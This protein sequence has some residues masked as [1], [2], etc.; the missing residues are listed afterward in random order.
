MTLKRT[1]THLLK[2]IDNKKLSKEPINPPK[3][4]ILSL[5]TELQAQ[6][7]FFLP[8]FDQ[9]SASQVCLLW[10]NIL[11]EASY[12]RY[13]ISSNP[14]LPSIHQI[15]GGPLQPS[16]FEETSSFWISCTLKK[17]R[18]TKYEYAEYNND[19]NGKPLL[20]IIDIS[21]HEFL[22]EPI[23]SP[24]T[25]IGYSPRMGRLKHADNY[26]GKHTYGFEESG[27]NGV[28]AQDGDT[29]LPYFPYHPTVASA[30]AE[31]GD[32]G[33]HE[34]P[35]VCMMEG[36]GDSGILMWEKRFNLTEGLTVRDA[37]EK[38][39]ESL[40]IRY[41][42]QEVSMRKK[43]EMRI[44]MIHYGS[45]GNYFGWKFEFRLILPAGEAKKLKKFMDEGLGVQY[46][47]P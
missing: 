7:L 41:E 33:V 35:S 43:R 45:E 31:E 10:H 30:K 47:I 44:R 12:S 39:V 27:R 17:W 18:V 20:R 13:P 32:I 34:C 38:V 23:L 24:F 37:I 26:K 29:Y 28:S 5:P 19:G 25:K 1:L 15:I 11:L 8:L 3:L 22:D 40:N 36:V 4:N 6:I 46:W 14:A 16:L 9:I 42:Y 21:K 2:L